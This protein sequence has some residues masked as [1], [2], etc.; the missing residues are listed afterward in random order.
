M[1]KPNSQNFALI[2]WQP[3]VS[4]FLLSKLLELFLSVMLFHSS[5]TNVFIFKSRSGQIRTKFIFHLSI[6]NIHIHW[7]RVEY[8]QIPQ[9]LCEHF[10]LCVPVGSLSG[11]GFVHLL[12]HYGISDH[13]LITFYSVT[14]LSWWRIGLPVC[15]G[16]WCGSGMVYPDLDFSRIHG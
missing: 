12:S 5:G 7:K 14:M 16:Q 9:N 11:L 6:F 4:I 10:F 13:G 15:P 8:W 3:T 2:V 1:T